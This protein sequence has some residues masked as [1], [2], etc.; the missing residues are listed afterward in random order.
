VIE[1]NGQPSA[2]SLVLYPCSSTRRPIQ[3]LDEADRGLKA[4]VHPVDQDEEIEEIM[5]ASSRH[6]DVMRH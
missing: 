1:G 2:A 5:S 6:V 3:V 4:T